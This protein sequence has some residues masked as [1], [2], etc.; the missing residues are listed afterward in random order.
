MRFEI[1]S[2]PDLV[3]SDGQTAQC[4]RCWRPI[5]EAAETCPSCRRELSGAGGYDVFHGEG[6]SSVFGEVFGGAL[7]DG[8]EAA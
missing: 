6:P 4:G 2:N 3:S 1:H 8:R 7:A 5:P